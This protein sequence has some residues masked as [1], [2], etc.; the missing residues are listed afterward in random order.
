[1][2]AKTHMISSVALGLGILELLQHNNIESLVFNSYDEL[3]TFLTLYIGAIIFGSVFPD[4]D[5]PHSYIGR[6]FPLFSNILSM[7]IEHRGITHTLLVIFLYSAIAYSVILIDGIENSFF[8]VIA[9]GFI[10]GNIGHILGDMMTK[11]GVA[12]LYPI[13]S[14][15]F[16]LLPK[17]LRFY[18][19]GFIEIVFMR[20]VFGL[21][22]VAEVLYQLQ[23]YG[24]I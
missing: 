3:I 11:S 14:K 15:N 9:I 21:I 2:T 20:I 19:G 18:T 17:R 16:G 12:L 22:V 8:I 10:V 7:F 13:T 23:M 4:I 24:V 5:E 1:M 6:K